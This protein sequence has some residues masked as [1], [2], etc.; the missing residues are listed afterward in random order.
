MLDKYVDKS[1]GKGCPNGCPIFFPMGGAPCFFNWNS[2]NAPLCLT[3][4]KLIVTFIF[5]NS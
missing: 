5:I 3:H 1:Q 2:L 4:F